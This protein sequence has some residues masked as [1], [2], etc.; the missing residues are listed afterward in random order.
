M[1]TFVN[2]RYIGQIIL[3]MICIFVSIKQTP[4]DAETTD[5]TYHILL[6]K[7]LVNLLLVVVVLQLEV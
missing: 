2:D 7:C 1:Y 3:Q 4:S 5:S 6:T